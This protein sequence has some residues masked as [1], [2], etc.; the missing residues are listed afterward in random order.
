MCVVRA[1]DVRPNYGAILLGE[2]KSCNDYVNFIC[3]AYFVCNQKRREI[4]KIKSQGDCS[5][6]TRDGQCPTLS[7]DF[8]LPFS[9]LYFL[10]VLLFFHTFFHTNFSPHHLLCTSSLIQISSS[11]SSTFISS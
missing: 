8:H 5:R 9:C 6:H 2:L 10:L 11:S 3:T 4:V 7:Y 1:T